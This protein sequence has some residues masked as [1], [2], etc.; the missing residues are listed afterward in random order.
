MSSIDHI[1]TLTTH[2]KVSSIGTKFN[3]LG[4]NFW[5]SQILCIYNYFLSIFQIFF[6]TFQVCN[7]NFTLFSPNYSSIIERNHWILISNFNYNCCFII[8]NSNIIWFFKTMNSP[9][10]VKSIFKGLLKFICLWV[11]NIDNSIFSATKNDGKFWVK[12]NWSNIVFM[13]FKCVNA[14]F[15]LI[16]PYFDRT[17]ISSRNNVRFI[18]HVTVIETIDSSLMTY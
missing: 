16:I 18:S 9:S 11:P 10:S 5:W 12:S 15:S 4:I 3:L 1:V 13:T 7:L 8:P 14:L 6:Q 2:C 17:I